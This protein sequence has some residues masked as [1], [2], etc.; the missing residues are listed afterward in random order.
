MKAVGDVL[1]ENN[2]VYRT[3]H[4]GFHLHYGRNNIVQNN[5]FAFGRDLQIARTRVEPGTML[6]FNRNIVYWDTGVF[7]LT[8][9]GS[10]SFD[11]NLYHCFGQG[12]L[13]FGKKKF[14]QWKAAGQ[15]VHS[16]LDDPGFI[17]PSHGD[18]SMPANS[19]ADKIHF[20]QFSVK[21]VGPRTR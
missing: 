13:T 21:D 9:A 18:F 15:D 17:D 10:I 12:K 11:E 16:I 3:T 6:T 4:G 20:V 8:D 5:I 7:T 1:I 14:E 2:L 19:A